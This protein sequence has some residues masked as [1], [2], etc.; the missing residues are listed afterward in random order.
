[1]IGHKLRQIRKSRNLTLQ[2]TVNGIASV[3]FLSSVENNKSDITVKKFSRIIE[4]L[5]ISESELYQLLI[6][7]EVDSQSD[8]NE[9]LFTILKSEDIFLFELT[10][11]KEKRYYSKN[12]NMRHRH[13]I[14]LLEQY[15]NYCLKSPI[16]EQQIKKLYQY[17]YSVDQWGIYECNLFGNCV[18][19][20]SAEKII[21]LYH[22]AGKN[23]AKVTDKKQYIQIISRIGFNIVINLLDK[24][25]F[26]NAFDVIQIIKKNLEET[27]LYY[28]VNKINYLYGVYLLKTGKKSE[29]LTKMEEAIHFMYKMGDNT[30]AIVHKQ[31]MESYLS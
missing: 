20:L 3:P 18:I 12:K 30:N 17:L 13:N 7:P 26:P 4:R 31:K 27:D 14:I 22:I 25:D 15:K 24:N 8:F 9:N 29:G 11:E 23:I 5:N 1:M 10:I 19:F 16:N 2:E 28:E 21:Q 6:N